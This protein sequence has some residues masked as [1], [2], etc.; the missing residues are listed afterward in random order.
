[1]R[2][3]M[4]ARRKTISGRLI[5]RHLYTIEYPAFILRREA[6]PATA[7]ID[8][9]P[10]SQPRHPRGV[11]QI[12]L[13]VAIAISPVV[14][15]SHLEDHAKVAT[16]QEYRSSR[17]QVLSRIDAAVNNHDLSTLRQ[18][19][20]KY[21]NCVQDPEFHSALDAGLAKLTAREAEIALLISKHLDLARH[22]E[23]VS[24][25]MNPMQPQIAH[26]DHQ[27]KSQRLSILP[28]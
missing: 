24:F 12:A 15:K 20:S 18:I 5:F 16:S 19:E 2:F 1:M 9:L 8:K 28:N 27:E 6:Q 14:I 23:E 11:I 25:R 17:S 10:Q 21:A 22:K 7:M 4:F 26:E 3:A 13:A